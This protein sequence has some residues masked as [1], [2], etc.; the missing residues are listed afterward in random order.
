MK[1]LAAILFLALL[2]YNAFGYYIV[3]AYEREQARIVS[4]QDLP[5]SAFE[6]LKF[7]LAIYTSVENTDFQYVNDEVTANGKTY[8]IIKKRI[9]NDSLEVYYLHNFRQDKLHQNLNDIVDAQSIC[10]QSKKNRP[11]KR[12]LSNFLKDYLPYNSNISIEGIATS[13]KRSLVRPRSSDNLLPIY[14]E[15]YSPPPEMV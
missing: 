1:Q 8:Q 6:V 13:R 15:H 2:L 5:E 4:L 10:K 7:N 9:Q 14:L 12:F 11:F 3:F